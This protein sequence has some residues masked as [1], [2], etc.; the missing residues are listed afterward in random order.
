LQNRVELPPYDRRKG[1]SVTKSKELQLSLLVDMENP[2]SVLDEV[3]TVV[4][5]MFPEFDFEHVNCVFEDVVRLFRGQY[6]GYQKCNIQYHDLKHT[7]DTL[8]GMASLIHG[9]MLNKLTFSE[10][11]VGLGLMCAL[12]HDTGLTLHSVYAQRPSITL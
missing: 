4:L 9:A 1:M 6:P 10:K 2:Q 7:T 11:N 5:M 3:K 12:F 8:L